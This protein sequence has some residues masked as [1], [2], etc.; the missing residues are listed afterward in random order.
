MN[1]MADKE[2]IKENISGPPSEKDSLRQAPLIRIQHAKGWFTLKLSELWEYREL[3]YFFIWRD[4]K[5]RYKQSVLGAAWAII[6]PFFSMVVFTIFF[7]KLAKMPSD[8]IPYPIFS[9][10]ALV[11]WM[12]FSNGLSKA[13]MSI[14]G[15][16]NLIK[17]V[18]FP[19][20]AIPISSVLSGG[21]DFI[22]AFIMLIGMMLY[23][24]IMPT[25]KVLWIPA[26]MVLA[27][28]TSL[29]VSLWL[30][31]L[32][33]TF[34]DVQHIIPFIVQFWMFVTPIVYPSSLVPERWRTIYAINPMAGV[35]EG[36]R[37]ALLG[38]N[39]SPAAIINVSSLVAI[40]ILL[41]GAW[42]FRRM[43]T[44]FADL[45]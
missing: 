9:F 24:G 36:F 14:V 3:I 34:R 13:S 37:W 4:I 22:I 21:V 35:I 12:F 19:R 29:G 41:S 45:T 26:L 28:I 32:N 16:S 33:V 2:N 23:F 40:V 11:P 42:Y 43:E 20:L 30:S 25:S 15:N 44:T 7:G 39:T 17:K 1:L 27:L 6:Q 10:A 31:A 5:V 18:Y 8:G 38:A